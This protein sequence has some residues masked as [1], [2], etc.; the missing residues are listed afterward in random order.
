MTW[1][2]LVAKE[3]DIIVITPCGFDIERTL[4]DMPILTGRAE[5]KE[6][7]AVQSGQIFVADGNQYFN[8]PGPRL[9]ESLQILAELFHPDIFQFGHKSRGWIRFDN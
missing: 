8:R 4:K 1:E 3:P 5:W 6:L 9:L 7:K 2:E